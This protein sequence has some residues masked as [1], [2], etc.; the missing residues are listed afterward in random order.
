MNTTLLPHPKSSAP[1]LARHNGT[2]PLPATAARKVMPETSSTGS[3]KTQISLLLVDDHPIVRRGIGSCLA[4]HP[5]LCVAGEAGDG[6]EALRKARELL[7]DIIL[8]DMDMPNMDGL[9]V[10]QALRKEL[11][12]AKILILSMHRHT[13]YVIRTLQ[14]GAMGYVLK[15]ASP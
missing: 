4:K 11:P 2:K 15:D 9:A 13:D 3:M 14:C 6:Q 7:P 1:L 10:T 5:N 12:K 8:M